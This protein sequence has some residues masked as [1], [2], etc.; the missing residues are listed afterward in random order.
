M[1][2]QAKYLILALGFSA[3]VAC[4]GEDILNGNGEDNLEL[5][6][7]EFLVEAESNANE[8][9]TITDEVLRDST[10]RAD[11]STTI[12]GVVVVKDAATNLITIDFGTGVVGS[13]GKVRK[14]IIS[15]NQSGQDFLVTGTK[16]SATFVGFKVDDKP[17]SGTFSVQNM[18]NF[19]FDAD[20]DTISFDPKFKYSANKTVQWLEGFST[21]DSIGDDKYQLT[22]TS[23]GVLTDSISASVNATITTAFVFEKACEYGILEGAMDMTFT[24]DSLSIQSGDIDFVAGDGI[25]NDGCNNIYKLNFSDGSSATLTFEGF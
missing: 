16:A 5:K 24:G 13:D 1:K 17:V 18:G 2:K 25:N 7:S 10:F 11:D 15:I 6:L 21:P 12:N 3:T 20:F 4:E 23:N 22:G 9:Y 8:L 19:S 14:G